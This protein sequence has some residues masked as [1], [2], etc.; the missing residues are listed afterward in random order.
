MLPRSRAHRRLVL[1]GI[2]AAVAVPCL[3]FAVVQFR[4]DASWQA[5]LAAQENLRAREAAAP[6]GREVAW[7]DATTGNAAPHYQRAL[8]MTRALLPA[9]EAALRR[10]LPHD[11]ESRAANTNGLLERWQPV[12]DALRD[13]AHAPEA[14][15][16]FADVDATRPFA[17]LL[18][19]RWIV[20]AAVLDAR[21]LRQRGE[22]LAA[23]R[24]TLDAAT[25]GA[26]LLRRGLLIDQMIGCA[27]LAIA[28]NEAWPDPALAALDRD[29]LD[30]LATGLE[31]LDRGLPEAID[32]TTEMLFSSQVLLQPHPDP[33]RLPM[34]S[35][36]RFLMSTRW[37]LADAMMRT[38]AAVHEIANADHQPW[39]QR[40]AL[41]ELDTDTL[42]RTGNPVLAMLMPNFVAAEQNRRESLAI[43]RLLRMAV[44]RHRGLD[45]PPLRDP[46]G[47]GPI[48]VTK[49]DGG[50]QL[51]CA[52]AETRRT[53]ARV[54]S[55]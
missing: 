48:V 35:A 24:R 2:V 46:L 45:V 16:P 53:L 50:V 52:G 30:A 5:M 3:G 12:L 33:A 9:D 6:R 29:A 41:I 28:T 43:L 49:V 4:A 21:V 1:A 10:T 7:G 42:V 51:R 15:P 55:R 32:L 25:F 37:M 38:F 27:M 40:R 47:D 8:A 17:N 31:R 18:T 13:G 20:N 26:D 14:V 34:P 22:Q 39:P 44:D 19:C 54:V 23:V 36:W 11:D